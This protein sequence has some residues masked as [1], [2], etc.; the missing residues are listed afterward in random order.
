MS[1]KIIGTD[2]IYLRVLQYS[3]INERYLSWFRDSKVTEFLEVNNL[4]CEDVEKY[5]EYGKNT[6]TYF[7][8][9]ICL[10][11]NELHVGNLKIGPIDKKHLISDLVVVIG[12]RDYWG[13]GLAR[14]AIKQ[15]NKIAFEVYG[16]R[17]LT[18]GMYSDNI[19][20][21]KCY[22]KAGWVEEARLK[23]HY[24]LNGKVLDRICV[25][26]FNPKFFGE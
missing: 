19:G 1:G 24:I 25:S 2:R 26:C 11:E 9:A 15:G 12:D 17:K 14:E 8:Y 5:I 21:I 23:G 22:T 4:T 20:S 16:I 6:G 13:Q 18:G 10:A 3:D 7:M